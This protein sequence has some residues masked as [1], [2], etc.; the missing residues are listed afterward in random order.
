MNE[1]LLWMSARRSGSQQSLRAKVAELRPGRLRASASFRQAE[2]DF[3]NLGHAEFGT[4]AGGPS[5]RIAPPVLAAG[6]YA[7]PCR[8]VLCGARS[9][10]LLDALAAQAGSEA[11]TTE[12]QQAA[13]DTV[14]VS[15]SSAQDLAALAASVGLPIQWN[16]P[17]AILLSAVP[18]WAARLDQVS[19]P[20]GG[21]TVSRFSKSQLSWVE[22]SAREAAATANGLFR[23][24]AE[25]Q[26]T[27]YVLFERGELYACD[28]ANAKYRVLRRVGRRRRPLSYDASTA[29]LTVP[30]SCRP[31][32]LAE[33]ALVVGSGRLPTFRE[34]RLVYGRVE[35]ST[36]AAVAAFLA[37]RLS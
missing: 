6:G 10:R 27:S 13:P 14:V 29:E 18:P 15:V 30:A 33:R 11:M 2:W 24:Q 5:W 32:A 36:A 35:P 21:W 19:M 8:A 7:G 31:P 37:Q 12:E 28:P 20:I 25:R 34:G 22:S 4:A 16:A 26:P 23:F 1:L 9:L 3:S 17:T